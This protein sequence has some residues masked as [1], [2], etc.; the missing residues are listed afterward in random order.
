MITREA[1]Q[2][3]E[4]EERFR[5]ERPPLQVANRTVIVVDDGLATGATMRATLRALRMLQPARLV[6]AAPVGPPDTC[7]ELQQDADEVVC[8]S[9]PA[10]FSSVGSHYD[11]FRPPADETVQQLLQEFDTGAHRLPTRPP[12]RDGD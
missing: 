5:G 6:A 10:S 8:L 3:K 12:C 2:V 7:Q 1:A 11:D 9:I 4:R